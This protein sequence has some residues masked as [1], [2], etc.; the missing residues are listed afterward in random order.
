MGELI[1]SAQDH[2]HATNVA[3]EM[4]FSNG[5]AIFSANERSTAPPP[6]WLL[7]AACGLAV[8]SPCSK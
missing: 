1:E 4:A 6:L 3:I 2:V 8:N 5:L 7:I